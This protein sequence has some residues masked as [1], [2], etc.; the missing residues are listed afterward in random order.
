MQAKYIPPH[1]RQS[2]SSDENPRF[3]TA[4]H[5]PYKISR[6]S[7]FNTR[8]PPANIS[9]HNITPIIIPEL[10][11]PPIVPHD[12]PIFILSDNDKMQFIIELTRST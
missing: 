2:N 8:H 6:G 1:K 10:I 9:S 7:Q 5:H 3:K 12:Q 4:N 11:I